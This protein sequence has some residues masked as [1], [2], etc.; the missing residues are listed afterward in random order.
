MIEQKGRK[1][2]KTNGKRMKKEKKWNYGQKE[3][4]V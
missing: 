4:E 2:M 3:R 1:N